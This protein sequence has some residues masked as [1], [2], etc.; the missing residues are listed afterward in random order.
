[1]DEEIVQ[2]GKFYTEPPSNEGQVVY[3]RFRGEN[4]EYSEEI[5][6]PVKSL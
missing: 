3:V 5:E 2:K 4:G 6:V 1:M